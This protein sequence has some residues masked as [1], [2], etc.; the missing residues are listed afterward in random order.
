MVALH[1]NEMREKELSALTQHISLKCMES[2]TTMML[3]RSFRWEQKLH[4]ENPNRG[5]K[6]R[7]DNSPRKN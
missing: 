3:H 7:G 1:T 2:L 4:F 6:V 5:R